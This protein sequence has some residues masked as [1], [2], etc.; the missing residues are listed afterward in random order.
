MRNLFKR[1]EMLQTLALTSGLAFLALVL[2]Y[3]MLTDK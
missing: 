3:L 2:V 1:I